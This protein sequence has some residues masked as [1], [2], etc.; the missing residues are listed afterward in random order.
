[1]SDN[2]AK[3]SSQ[4]IRKIV[5]HLSGDEGWHKDGAEKFVAH[6]ELLVSLGIDNPDELAEMLHELY[7][8]VAQEYGA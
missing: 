2:K 3:I 4:R 8:A 7:W 1:M 5:A 6:A